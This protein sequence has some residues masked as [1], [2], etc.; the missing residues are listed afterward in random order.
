MPLLKPNEGENKD[1]FLDRCMANDVM[2]EEYPDQSQRAAVCNAQFTVELAEDKSKTKGLSVEIFAVGVWHGIPFTVNDLNAIASAFHSLKEVHKVPLKMGHNE[3]QDITD[4]M[5]ALGWVEDVYVANGSDGKPKLFAEF[6]DM[7]EIVFSAINQK[8]YRKVSVELDF[9]VEH[10]GTQYSIVL[11]GVALLGAD[12][13]AVNT[14][15]DLDHY[16][17]KAPDRLAASRHVVFSSI[18]INDDLEE[19]NM[20]DEKRIA[21]LEAALDEQK[22]ATADAQGTV[23]KFERDE[24]TRLDAE[25]NAKIKFAR[26]TVTE[27]FETAVKEM[28]ITPVQKDNF[29]KLLNVDDDDAVVGIN[30]EAVKKLIE[31]N[32]VTDF[33]RDQS[34]GGSH[35]DQT[36]DDA[37]DALNTRAME[38]QNNN[39]GMNFSTA[40]ERA[41]REKP[42]LAKQH[43]RATGSIGD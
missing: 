3:E 13:P 8:S 32:K 17:D 1:D 42:E 35:D 39:Q 12:L 18:S 2:N 33:S 24:A 37:G 14:L 38:I 9:G 19:P 34:Q 43:I 28:K 40:L 7:P 30:I 26:E 16:I 21:D 27:I 41:M 15:A 11:S 36:A 31:D 10:K 23:A 25:N 29:T 22:Q 6:I 20:G 4:G 5:H